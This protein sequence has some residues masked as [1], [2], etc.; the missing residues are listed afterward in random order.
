[1]TREENLEEFI[2]YV[3]DAMH[4]AVSP[5]LRMI[6]DQVL[7]GDYSWAVEEYDPNADDDCG[8]K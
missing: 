8:P 7:K 2:E 5:E 6:A 4:L 1:M 3:R